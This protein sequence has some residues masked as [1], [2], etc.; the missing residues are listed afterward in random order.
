MVTTAVLTSAPT[1]V[2]AQSTAAEAGVHHWLD[3]FTRAFDAKDTKAVMALY[4]PDVIAYDIVPPLQYTGLD[5]YGKDFATFFAQYKGPLSIE[6]RDVH[7]YAS[8]DLALLTCLER[9][10]GTLANG[11]P[12]SMWLRATTGLRRV[13]GHW[14]DFHDHI[15]VP[16]DF[17]TGK[18]RLDLQP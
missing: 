12:S 10:S 9:V 14:L 17:D 11:Q 6:Y 15:S 16:T 4:A 13:N 2:L 3:D 5:S 7:I 8:G 1:R 18:S